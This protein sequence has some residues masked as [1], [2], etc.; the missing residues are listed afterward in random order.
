LGNYQTAAFTNP[1][2]GTPANGFPNSTAAPNLTPGEPIFLLNTDFMVMRISDSAQ[3]GFGFSGFMG[4]PDSE[5]VVGRIKA[6]GNV[7]GVPRYHSLVYGI[8]S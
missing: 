5:K 3:Y 7:Q 6:A 1:L 8:G 4:T 2:T